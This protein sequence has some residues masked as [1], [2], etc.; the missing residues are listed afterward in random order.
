MDLGCERVLGLGAVPLRAL[1]RMRSLWL[2][3][4]SAG[5]SDRTGLVSGIGRIFRLRRLRGCH[6]RLRL[7]GVGAARAVRAVL[8]LVS[9]VGSLAFPSA[10][11]R[12]GASGSSSAVA[13]RAPSA[14]TRNSSER[15]VPQSS[16]WGDGCA[17]R[18]ISR[19][20]FSEARTIDPNQLRNIVMIRG[21]LPIT[22][23]A[24]NLSFTKA[25]PAPHVQFSRDFT[26]PRF[27]TAAGLPLRTQFDSQRQDVHQSLHARPPADVP[28]ESPG[29]AADAWNHFERARPPGESP[30]IPQPR[31]Y[32]ITTPG[33]PQ[34]R[35]PQRPVAPPP[36]PPESPPRPPQSP[37]RPPSSGSRPP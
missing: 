31:Q 12:P 30:S 14:L 6:G 9:G 35:M 19:R 26:Q 8:S 5:P 11:P 4:V 36:R 24:A 21:T 32:P 1:V 20:E 15:H 3:L 37:S 2:V 10:Q 34:P 29:S 7:L 25:V 17:R 28:A 33:E 18:R 16:Q 23:T 13:S 22:P 27:D